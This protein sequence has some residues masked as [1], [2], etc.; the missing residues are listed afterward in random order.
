[1]VSSATHKA[2]VATKTSKI[3]LILGMALLRT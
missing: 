1:M 3:A 2:I